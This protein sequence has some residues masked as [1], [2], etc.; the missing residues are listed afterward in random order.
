[1]RELD[2]LLLRYLERDHPAAS[3][4]ERDAFARLLDMQDP[5]IF[6]Y[7]VGRVAPVEADLRHVV[8]RIRRA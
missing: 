7:L 6:G 3:P 4:R 1:M 5:E 8:D 2:E